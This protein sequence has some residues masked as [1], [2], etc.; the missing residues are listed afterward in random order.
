MSI[1]EQTA[2]QTVEIADQKQLQLI[3]D[4]SGLYL[5]QD[6][7]TIPESSGRPLVE[8]MHMVV[9]NALDFYHDHQG[10]NK[11]VEFAGQELGLLQE[12]ADVALLGAD[13]QLYST[14]YNLKM[15]L[16]AQAA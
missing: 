9:D 1:G 2:T 14:A 16:Q 5:D 13:R 4:V 10:P 8:V 7:E 15:L 11:S 12:L 6:L 3:R